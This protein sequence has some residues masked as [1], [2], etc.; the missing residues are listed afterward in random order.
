MSEEKKI[1]IQEIIATAGEN[2][3]LEVGR[4]YMV[5][6]GDASMRVCTTDAQ[7]FHM[8]AKED[9]TTE[10]R[11]FQSKVSDETD[12]ESVEKFVRFLVLEKMETEADFETAFKKIRRIVKFVPTKANIISCYSRLVATGQLEKTS[13]IEK[14]VLKKGIRS[15]SGV[16]VITVVSAPG[17]FSCPQDCAYC[18]NEPGQPRSYL[19]TEPA[20]ARANQNKFDPV[21]QVYDRAATLAR[22]GHK[23]D[24]IEIIVL[25]GTWS[26][27]PWEYQQQFCRDIFFAANTFNEDL[28]RSR[29]DQEVPSGEAVQGL[30]EEDDMPCVALQLNP[31][32][33]QNLRAKKTLQEEQELNESADC[34]IIG[35]TLET[36]PDHISPLEIRRLRSLGC[37]RVQ[38]GVQHTDDE[39]LKKIN[40]GCTTADAV[41]AVKLL[42][43]HCFKVDIHLMPDLPFSS[44]E[45]DKEMFDFVLDT[46]YLQADH[47]KIYPCEV[48]PFSAIEDWH[49]QGSYKPY[50]DID[51]ENLVN[52]LVHVKAKVHP[53]IRL[54]RVIRDI[55]VESIIAGNNNTN[56]RQE[57]Y[58][59]L[60]ERGLACRCIRCREV[61]A[62]RPNEQVVMRRRDYRSSE[63]DEIFL[64]F[65]G[66]SSRGLGGG[67]ENRGIQA[68]PEKRKKK[69]Q[70]RKDSRVSIDSKISGVSGDQA[71][72][73][74]LALG[75]TYDEDNAPL[76]ALLRLRFNDDMH[77][78]CSTF[79]ELDE[80]ALIRELHVYGVV[81]PARQNK[82]ETD[83]V[84]HTGYGRR[85]MAEAERIAL[86]R[87]YKKIAVIAGIGVRNY[88]RKLGYELRGL[89]LVKDLDQKS[90]RVESEVTPF[91]S[92]KIQEVEESTIS[93]WEGVKVSHTSVGLGS[94]LLVAG[95]AGLWIYKR[96][97]R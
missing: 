84:Q 8:K 22:Q 6:N 92:H 33:N 88:Y 81:A 43:Q 60:A 53:W 21:R 72:E 7:E 15:N 58:K 71:D 34:K 25:G 5:P 78:P 50:T 51:P 69:S 96:L 13:S 11:G 32:F 73:G 66:T 19:S 61:R 4:E 79:P 63:G 44:V 89:F 85:L 56:L 62:F 57:V 46:E 45:S 83:T 80:C 37:T 77:A 74:S 18:P 55:P 47:W 35:L 9:F 36:R 54:N 23:I 17:P 29:L 48:T 93:I 38:I 64:T 82:D 14:V 42:K 10:W 59:R 68:K 90:Y 39:I 16:V 95:L 75:D 52:L 30:A 3:A 67:A 20:V 86:E 49:A 76:Y 94:A 28:A 1:P 26:N 2:V 91:S 87:G 97:Q 31:Q 24:K 70:Q 40:R 41:K 12:W 65:E 27:Y